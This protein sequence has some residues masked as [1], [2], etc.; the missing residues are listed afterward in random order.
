[1]AGGP[2]SVEI[3]EM[4]GGPQSVE[5]EEMAG[6][7]QSVEIEEMAGGP[8][9]QNYPLHIFTFYLFNILFSLKFMNPCIVIQL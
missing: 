4:E 1:M 5:I 9:T 8:Q 7:P 2:Q 3:E 6:G